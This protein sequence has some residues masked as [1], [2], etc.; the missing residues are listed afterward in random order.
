MFM[1]RHE[2][3]RIR[4]MERWRMIMRATSTTIVILTATFA[5]MVTF[6]VGKAWAENP[7][8]NCGDS[9]QPSSVWPNTSGSI[10]IENGK[11]SDDVLCPEPGT[12]YI[13]GKCTQIYS[14]IPPRASFPNPTS[15]CAASKALDD[16][17][18]LLDTL[19]HRNPGGLVIANGIDTNNAL[20]IEAEA[21]VG[22]RRRLCGEEK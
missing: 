22:L 13:G 19:K 8:D 5:G 21:I 17:D 10:S 2:R 12:I 3:R 4:R 1:P 14:T 18:A 11:S 16:L 6:A 15:L 9:C 7:L 20:Q